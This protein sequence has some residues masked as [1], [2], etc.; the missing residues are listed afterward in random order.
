MKSLH[1]FDP[2][3]NSVIDSEDGT[4]NRSHFI[5]NVYYYYHWRT[6]EAWWRWPMYTADSTEQEEWR[7]VSVCVWFV[8]RK[9]HHNRRCW[10]KKFFRPCVTTLRLKKT[11][12]GLLCKIETYKPE[13]YKHGEGWRGLKWIITHERVFLSFKYIFHIYTYSWSS[14][15]RVGKEM[16]AFM[17]IGKTHKK[18]NIL[19]K[20]Y[21]TS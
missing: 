19:N 5:W 3:A 21:N 4:K 10:Q 2:G 16:H 20:E 11:T 9:L 6:K 1:A 17:A 13:R 14:S 15:V 8:L 12:K 7:F 18:L